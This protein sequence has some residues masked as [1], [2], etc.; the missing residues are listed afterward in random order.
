MTW[1]ATMPHGMGSPPAPP[2][3]L[4]L[5]SFGGYVQRGVVVLVDCV[6]LAAHGHKLRQQRC[7][8]C[9]VGQH[10]QLGVPCSVQWLAAGRLWKQP[11]VTLRQFAW[12]Q[13]SARPHERSN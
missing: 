3:H 1:R 7:W 4:Y 6:R 11:C 13:V 5:A 8:C 12:Q 10:M 9:S 2:T